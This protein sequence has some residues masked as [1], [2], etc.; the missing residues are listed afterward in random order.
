MRCSPCYRTLG[1]ANDPKSL[2]FG[3][4]AYFPS[5]ARSLSERAARKRGVGFEVRL[6]LFGQSPFKQY[7][8]A[9]NQSR[10]LWKLQRRAN[11]PRLSVMFWNT[12]RPIPIKR[13][14]DTATARRFRLPGSPIFVTSH[15]MM[16]R[17]H[18]LPP[19]ISYPAVFLLFRQKRG[20]EL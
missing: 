1:H 17:N 2:W 11:F 10:K 12:L 20:Q 6:A 9:R 7:P 18:L 3:F 4:N 19:V 14:A 5:F 15:A 16:D 8:A 13:A